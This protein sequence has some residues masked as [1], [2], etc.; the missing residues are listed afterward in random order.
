[1]GTTITM[2]PDSSPLDKRERY[3]HIA[4]LEYRVL[5]PESAVRVLIR[6]KELRDKPL[7]ISFPSCEDAGHPPL[8]N[9]FFVR[10][11]NTHRLF[12]FM[13]GGSI[14]ARH[15]GPHARRAPVP[16]TRKVKA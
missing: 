15:V 13:V 11:D 3:I 5:S 9:I 7:K 2:R 6:L 8:N 1:M 16:R 4:H 14:P 10:D 12:K